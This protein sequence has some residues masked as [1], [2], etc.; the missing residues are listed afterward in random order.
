ML[1]MVIMIKQKNY[2]LVRLNC[3]SILVGVPF[4]RRSQSKD[5]RLQAECHRVRFLK[6]VLPKLWCKYTYWDIVRLIY[7]ERWKIV[8]CYHV[9]RPSHI[10]SKLVVMTYPGVSRFT[11][12]FSAVS[13]NSAS[14]TGFVSL[15]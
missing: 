1:T 13:M 14:L 4:Q 7:K 15:L 9:S 5:E 6:P 10:I 11:K 8:R 3:Q 2:L 12:S